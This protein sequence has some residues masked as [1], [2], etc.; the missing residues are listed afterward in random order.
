MA[1][2]SIIPTIGSTL[3]E[4]ATKPQLVTTSQLPPANSQPKASEPR[5]IEMLTGL[6]LSP[7]LKI[8]VFGDS[9]CGKTLFAATAPNPIFLDTQNSTTSLRDWPSLAAKCNIARIKWEHTQIALDMLRDRTHDLC[10]D[11]ETVVLD[12]VDSLQRMNLEHVLRG[13]G[14]DP[15]LPMEHDY[16]KSGEMLRRFIMDLRDLPMHVIVCMDQTEIIPEG[17]KQRFIRPGVT[18]KLAK[19]LREEFD[20]LGYM[21]V[22]DESTDDRFRNGLMIR[23]NGQI[24]AKSHFRYLPTIIE[25]PTFDTILK[26]ANRYKEQK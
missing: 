7:W 21:A 22:H 3:Q 4:L 23:S 16:K 2:S 26:A 18:P 10:Q 15:F 1:E 25:N 19:T 17:S 12:T 14:R 13:S 6:D 11:R 8:V 24:Q 5:P 20:L 9:G